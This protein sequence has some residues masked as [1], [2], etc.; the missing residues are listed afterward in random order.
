[1]KDRRYHIFDLDGTMADSMG[2]WSETMLRILN[3]ADVAYPDDVIKLITPMGDSKA[4]EYFISLGVKGTPDQIIEK[5]RSIGVEKYRSLIMPKDG[6][7]EYLRSLKANGCRLYVLTASPH[8]YI[9]PFLKRT[10]LCDLFDEAFTTNDFGRAKSDVQIYHDLAERIGAKIEDMVF[11][12]DNEIALNTGKEAGLYVVGVYD[13]SSEEY[14]EEIKK[15]ANK[16]IKT[17]KELI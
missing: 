6:V 10:G 11:Y 13:A 5:M 2:Y 17:F 15:T 9:D 3:E 7:E 8:E 14:T 16:Y 4:A 12:D 1:M